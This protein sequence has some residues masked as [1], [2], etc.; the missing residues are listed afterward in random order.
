MIT[1]DRNEF[2]NTT[3]WTHHKHHISCG[4][5]TPICDPNA[6]HSAVHMVVTGAP[7]WLQT[8]GFNGTTFVFEL[9]DYNYAIASNAIE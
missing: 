2:T 8:Q 7:N 9:T 1:L 3:M 5:G 6:V 4:E